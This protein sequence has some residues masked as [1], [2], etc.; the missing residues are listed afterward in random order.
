MS[1]HKMQEFSGKLSNGGV[2]GLTATVSPV[3]IYQIEFWL[4]H[5][6]FR[7]NV[8]ERCCFFLKILAST[9]DSLLA[10]VFLN[11]ITSATA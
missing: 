11:E 1:S 10:R 6:H 5:N 4:R 8:M 2:A 9:V 7:C 3:P